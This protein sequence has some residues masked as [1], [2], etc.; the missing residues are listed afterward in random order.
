MVVPERNIPTIFVAFGATGDLMR[1]K[2]VPAL[3]HLFRKKELPQ[4]FCIIGFGRRAWSDEEF[5][6]HVRDIIEK[7]GTH[8]ADAAFVDS[9]LQ[10]F[11][12]QEGYAENTES[13][14]ALKKQFDILDKEWGVCA[15]KLFYLA[16]APE[17]YEPICTNLSSSHLSDPCSPEE[18]WT[19]VIVEKP[20]GTDYESARK[21]DELLATLFRE[22]QI[23]RIDHY[24]AKEMLQNILTFRFSNNLFELNWDKDFIERIDMR[25]LEEI[26][27]EKRGAFY[28][29]VGALRD[30][31]QNHLL[32]MLALITMER[33]ASFAAEDIRSKR[34][35]ILHALE[36]PSPKDVAK[37]SFRAQY[38]GYRSITGVAPDSETETYFKVRARFSSDR[39]K[40]VPLYMEAGK[41][42]GEPLKEIR[43]LFKHPT[44]CLCPQDAEHH[45]NEVVI[46]MEPKEEIVI[47]FWSKKP[48]YTYATEP[49][50]FHFLLREQAG[51]VQYT[52]E[53]ERLLLDCIRGD[54]TLFISTDEIRAMWRYTDPIVAAWKAGAVPMKT[55]APGEKQVTKEAGEVLG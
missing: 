11:R 47:E 20:F 1:L 3:F 26:G 55:Y 35:E 43:I 12:F 8:G 18:G 15:N 45:K 42:L 50:M 46:R 9:F 29:S 32:Q 4:H 53:Y 27:V 54:Q 31:G 7:H 22:E 51:R 38:D 37:E 52:E 30:V 34:A 39:W 14:I 16:V 21:L 13:Y 41:R 49:R 6:S 44:P 33:P 40:G 48:G 25:L 28:D 23:Y 19:R 10:L 36:V 2:V 24:L 17:L 5:R